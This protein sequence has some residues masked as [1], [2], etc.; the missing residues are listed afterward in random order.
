MSK[1]EMQMPAPA[2]QNLIEARMLSGQAFTYGGL[3]AEFAGKTTDHNEAKRIAMLIDRTIQRLRR[4]GLISYRRS[5]RDTIW[6][7]TEAAS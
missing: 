1:A 7:R 2:E 6:R 5:G 4:K 3:V